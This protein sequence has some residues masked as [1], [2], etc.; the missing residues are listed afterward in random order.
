MMLNIPQLL[1]P[2]IRCGS[3]LRRTGLVVHGTPT[4]P[5]VLTPRAGWQPQVAALAVPASPV[6]GAISRYQ[7]TGNTRCNLQAFASSTAERLDD[8]ARS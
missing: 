4:S 2:L 6:G 3:A 1:T 5:P 7:Q 8:Y